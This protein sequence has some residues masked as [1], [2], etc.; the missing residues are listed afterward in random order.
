MVPPPLNRRQ[1]LDASDLAG[2]AIVI[3]L[4]DAAGSRPALARLR[5]VRLLKRP[6]RRPWFFFWPRVDVR[7]RASERGNTPVLGPWSD[8]GAYPLGETVL[9]H[10]RWNAETGYY[11]TVSW[12]AVWAAGPPPSAFK[13][14]LAATLRFLSPVDPGA[15]KSTDRIA[16]SATERQAILEG[17][18]VVGVAKVLSV[19]RETPW[20]PLM[21]TLEFLKIDKGDLGEDEDGPRKIVEVRLRMTRPDGAPM[22]LWS[23]QGLYRTG[24][25]VMAHLNWDEGG[26]S[27]LQTSCANGVWPVDPR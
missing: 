17:A 16:P 21:A 12:N 13:K 1:L 25:T 10:L 11:E 26:R 22:S 15:A 19:E 20:R 7:L 23:D 24:E 5:F 14:A 3:G 8:Q 27:F 18:E 6:L 2:C 9:T 4:K